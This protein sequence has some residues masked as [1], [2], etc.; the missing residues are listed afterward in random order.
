MAVTFWMPDCWTRSRD[1]ISPLAELVLEFIEDRVGIEQ[2]VIDIARFV[3]VSE[4]A[5]IAA[6]RELIGARERVEVS[7]IA[8]P[9]PNS[10]K[11][12]G[13]FTDLTA[14]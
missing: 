13:T 2:R 1:D 11:K 9:D 5:I 6:C 12:G 8:L 14:S 4:D 10:T 7:V 3:E